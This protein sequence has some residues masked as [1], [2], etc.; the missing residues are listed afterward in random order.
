MDD[1]DRPIRRSDAASVLAK[2]ALDSYSRAELDLR[3][4]LLEDEIAR[5]KAHRNKAEAHRLAAEAFF[6]PKAD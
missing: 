2:E 3:V 6:K 4:A 1:D 5:V